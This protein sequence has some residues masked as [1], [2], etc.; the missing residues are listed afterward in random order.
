[1]RVCV[2][3]AV[4]GSFDSPQDHEPQVNVNVDIRTFNDSNFPA[5][6]RTL[7]RRM[8]ARIPKAFGWDIL[9]GYDAYIWL[10]GSLRLS[11]PDSVQW[12]L[13]HLGAGDIAVFKHPVRSSIAEEMSFIEAKLKAGSHYIKSRYEGEDLEGQKREL[14]A[15]P[16]YVDTNLY[17][18]GA[19]C[20]RPTPKIKEAFKEWWYH[21]SR[22]HV[23]DQFMFPYCLRHC[24][25]RV[26][27]EDIYHSSHLEMRRHCG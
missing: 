1:M 8:A 4:F 23:S 7:S 6:N 5:R 11:K 18:N 15:D 13:N 26:I 10:D 9:P 12:F 20:Y 24:D 14:L 2:H 16:A 17:A 19:F 22:Y 27:D 3:S 25:V 21:T